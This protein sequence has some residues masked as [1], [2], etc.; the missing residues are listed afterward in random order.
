MFSANFFL[1]SPS[2]QT[3]RFK[4]LE[5]TNNENKLTSHVIDWKLYNLIVIF[6]M[7]FIIIYFGQLKTTLNSN[8]LLASNFNFKILP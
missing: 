8:S 3:W 4:S 7:N 1:N 5:M 6:I 2:T